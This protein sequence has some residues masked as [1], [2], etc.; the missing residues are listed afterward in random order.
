MTKAY[1][2]NIDRSLT[3]YEYR[4]LS[5]LLSPEKHERIGRFHH[6]EDAQRS[7]LGDALA[8]MA[9]NVKSGLHYGEI[10]FGVNPYG[11][12]FLVNNP[13]LHFNISHSTD[14]VACVIDD[15]PCGIDVEAIKTIDLKIAERFFCEQEREYILNTPM[16]Y[17]S[18][19]FYEIWT[20]KEAYIK[21]DG[22]GLSL[23]LTSFS[24]LAETDSVYFHKIAANNDM[25]CHVCSGSTE[26]VSIK[27][28]LTR[29]VLHIEENFMTAK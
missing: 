16:Q 29:L 14:Y 19:A 8:K 2:V 24:V 13:D 6:Y 27:V 25:I 17:H 23:P 22:R 26:I 21:R 15:D 7:L 4:A 9:I 28:D 12:P 1:I 11:K 5:Q 18:R 10:N 3:S 20:M